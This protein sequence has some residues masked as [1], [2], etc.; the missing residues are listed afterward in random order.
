MKYLIVTPWLNVSCLL[1]NPILECDASFLGK[2]RSFLGGQFHTRHF[3][4]FHLT[5]PRRQ[6]TG[7][8]IYFCLDLFFLILKCLFHL[9]L[10]FILESPFLALHETKNKEKYDSSLICNRF[11]YPCM[12]STV[13]SGS[14]M[15]RKTALF[16]Y[17]CDLN[18]NY[19]WNKFQEET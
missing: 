12:K 10:T 13:V 3:Y 6:Q 14:P 1:Q 2:H 8:V 19:K 15:C 16:C 7:N 18:V 9:F 17:L 5:R 4:K 11:L